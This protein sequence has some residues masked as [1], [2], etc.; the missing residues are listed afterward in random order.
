MTKRI[1]DARASDFRAMD[2]P[3]LL[4]SIRKAEG[5]TVAAEIV[6]SSAPLVDGVTNVEL[7]AAFGADL[8]ILNLY[9]LLSPGVEGAPS[10]GATPDSIKNLIGRPVGLNLEPVPD[11]SGLSPGRRA[12]SANAAAALDQGAD[13]IVLTGNPG[14]G[15]SNELI[16]RRV[17]EAVRAVGGKIPIF[18]GKMHGAGV[19]AEEGTGII[20]PSGVDAFL[21][22]GADV[23]LFPAPGTVPGITVEDIRQLVRRV[24]SRGGL[25]M[26]T[27]GTSQ[28]GADE[29]TIRRLAIDAKMTG[30]DIYHIGDAGYH[31]VAVPE[32][33]L[34][35]SIA[36]RGRRHTYRRMA[37]SINR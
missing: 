9:D 6:V 25:A 33:I 16:A 36:L 12:T 4:E 5:R 21:G 1:L 8:L 10:P 7:A 20:G 24:H 28:E 29:Q 13:F 37:S 11:D 34:A 14:T 23:I 18:A 32:N 22:A 2:R 26:V 15:V 27:I 17:A 3:A 35:Y 30:A 19:A 31:G